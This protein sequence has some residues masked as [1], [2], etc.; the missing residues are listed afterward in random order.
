MRGPQ[1]RSRRHCC[2]VSSKEADEEE[3]ELGEASSVREQRK[4][5]LINV[6]DN[7]ILYERPE[8]ST[9]SQQKP[10]WTVGLF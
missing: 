3:A 7:V 4:I 10:T 5:K 2:K 6:H 8:T 1:E 9:N